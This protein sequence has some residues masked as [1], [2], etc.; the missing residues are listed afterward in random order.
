MT[1][2]NRQELEA[3]YQVF[4][5]FILK[6]QKAYYQKAIV[7]N[8]KAANQVN[9]FRG[10]CA[11]LAAIAAGSAGVIVSAFFTGDQTCAADAAARAGYCTVAEVSTVILVILA[12]ILPSIG[13]IF[14]T[15]M[16]LY[17]WDRVSDLYESATE[18]LEVAD[19]L[20][21]APGV[22]DDEQYRE[23]FRVY[24]EGALTIMNAETSQWGQS[25]RTPEELKEF[26][27]SQHIRTQSYR[28]RMGGMPAEGS[29]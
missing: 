19:A 25:I 2:I 18:N 3:R 14:S 24:A 8:R 26:V 4:D 15:L 5:R 12:M 13:S 20:S 23:F 16:E 28:R 10:L 9:R 21:P 11:A 7:R 6:D 1:E 17:Q 29:S 22:P 27:S